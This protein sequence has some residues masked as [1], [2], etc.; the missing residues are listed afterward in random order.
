LRLQTAETLATPICFARFAPE[1]HYD[2]HLSVMIVKE[3]IQ[4][5]NDVDIMIGTPFQDVYFLHRPLLCFIVLPSILLQYLDSNVD[6]SGAFCLT[7][8]PE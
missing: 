5:P 3:H 1:L 2:V 7:H 6:A 4:D 8:Y